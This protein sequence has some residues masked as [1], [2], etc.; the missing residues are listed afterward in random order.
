MLFITHTGIQWEKDTLRK[1]TE[2][3]N[4]YPVDNSVFNFEMFFILTVV[5]VQL[6]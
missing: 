2:E 3:T 5:C 1:K 6:S 4:I